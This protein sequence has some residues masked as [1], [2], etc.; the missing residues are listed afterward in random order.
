M[1]LF[2]FLLG[3]VSASYAQEI[4]PL[5]FRPAPELTT[6]FTP[7]KFN[8]LPVSINLDHLYTK[9]W[10]KE[11]KE[12][13]LERSISA[14]KDNVPEVYEDAEEKKYKLKLKIPWR[15]NDVIIPFPKGLTKQ[16]N[17][18]PYDPAVAYQRSALFPGWGQAYNQ[19][20][21]KIP[22]FY[23]G[24]GGFVWWINYNNSR[25]RRF[26]TAFILA[27]DDDSSNDDAELMELYDKEG[28]RTQRN[29]FRSRRDNAYL[30][31][32]GWHVVQIAEAY[33]HAHLRGFD[34]SE[35]L[36]MKAFPDVLKIDTGVGAMGFYPGFSFTFTF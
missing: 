25:Y 23:V 27:S 30:L 24:Y 31:L 21:W 16:P 32:A 5:K 15:E 28:L 9:K 34:V 1:L 10:F 13:F 12:P 4:I 33:V 35:D 29:Q 22:F 36:S 6:N 17:P 19:S 11:D 3:I 2:L 26:G 14:I 20:Y 8:I 7:R 18:P